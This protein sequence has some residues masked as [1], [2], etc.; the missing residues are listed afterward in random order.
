M[1]SA[2][3]I[4]CTFAEQGMYPVSCHPH[5]ASLIHTLVLELVHVQVDVGGC[6]PRPL[7]HP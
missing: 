3:R 6:G 2:T 5:I 4:C 1:F 7:L